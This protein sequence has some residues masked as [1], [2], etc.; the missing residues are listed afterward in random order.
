MNAPNPNNKDINDM[1]APNPDIACSPEF[2]QGCI[3]P[4][5]EDQNEAT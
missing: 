3:E 4:S 5:D 2:S 1:N